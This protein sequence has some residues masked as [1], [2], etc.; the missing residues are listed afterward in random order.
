MRACRIRGTH[1]CLG[2]VMRPHPFL[3]IVRDFRSAIFKKLREQLLKKKGQLTDAGAK[4]VVLRQYE[5]DR[6]VAWGVEAADDGAAV[7]HL[8]GVR[9][10]VRSLYE[11]PAEALWRTDRLD[12]VLLLGAAPVVTDEKTAVHLPLRR[13]AAVLFAARA[14]RGS[15]CR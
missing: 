5:T 14:L 3:S 2:A 11:A 10:D 12:T 1:C 4:A 13:C 8:P 7:L 6:A 15:P 9:V